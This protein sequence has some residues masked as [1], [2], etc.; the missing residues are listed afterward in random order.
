MDQIFRMIDDNT[1]R[2]IDFLCHICSYEARAYDKETL[3]RMADDIAAFARSEGFQVTRT[4]MEACGDF[5]TIEINPGCEK[6]GLFM[7]HMDTVFDKGVFGEPPVRRDE[8]RM[9]GPGV[10]D[11][12]GG[13]AISLL[14]MK[15]LLE[16]GRRTEPAADIMLSRI[17][18]S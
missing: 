9:Y 16:R 14:C 18:R 1:E 8:T 17:G 5:L 15:A 7:A 12:K 13:I 10:I 4:P 2:Y 3:D 6:A 11:C